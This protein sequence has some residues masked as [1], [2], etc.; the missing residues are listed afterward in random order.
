MKLSEKITHEIGCNFQLP[1]ICFTYADY[2][3][4][5]KDFKK[6]DAYLQKGMDYLETYGMSGWLEYY[7]N[8]Y[9]DRF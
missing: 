9:A 4:H 8:R 6:A 7:R 1:F 3:T 5:E 2:Y